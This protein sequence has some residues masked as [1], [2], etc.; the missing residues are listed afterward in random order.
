[1]TID[2]ARELVAAVQRACPGQKFSDVAPK[3]WSELLHDLKL[4]ECLVA[5]GALAPFSR[6]ITFADIRG[7]VEMIHRNR[8]DPSGDIYFEAVARRGGREYEGGPVPW[9]GKS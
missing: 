7:R 2:E 6:E 1:M 8:Q 3:R 9:D 5:V 4:A